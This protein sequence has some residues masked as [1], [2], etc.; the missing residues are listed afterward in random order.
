M[1]VVV[2]F[3]NA[4]MLNEVDVINQIYRFSKLKTRRGIYA[5]TYIF[6]EEFFKVKIYHQNI[7]KYKLR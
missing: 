6:L 7:T 3:I 2:G 1:S 4:K 5:Q